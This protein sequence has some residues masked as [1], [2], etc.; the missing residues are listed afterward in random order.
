[1]PRLMPE[2]SKRL[3]SQTDEALQLAEASERVRI[4]LSAQPKT[5]NVLSTS[6]VR[7]T[8]EMAY[9]RIFASWEA[10]LE[11]S[12]IRYLCG[13]SNSTGQQSIVSG[14][15]FRSLLDARRALLGQQTFVLWHNPKKVAERGKKFF[16]QGVHET[17]LMSSLSRL[18]WF[19]S[20]RHRIAH[21]HDDAKRHFDSACMAL[22]GRRFPGGRPGSFL[23]DTTVLG[24]ARTRWLAIISDELCDLADQIIQ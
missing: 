13:Y 14:S 5:R 10:F 7:L 8:Y 19:A 11:D 23:R 24:N 4:I 16:R 21:N 2:L 12:F 18:E 15:Y 20:V 17:T 1:M 6:Q 3:R 22:C 9:L